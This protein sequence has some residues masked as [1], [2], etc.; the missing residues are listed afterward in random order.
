MGYKLYREVLDHASADLTATERLVLAVIADDANDTTRESW[1]PSP[2]WLAH[3]A[4]ST[5]TAIH[6]AIQRL[7]RRGYELRVPVKVGVDGRPVYAHK[8]R[9]TTYRIP[10]FPARDVPPRSLKARTDC[11]PSTAPAPVDNQKSPDNLSTQTPVDNPAKGGQVVPKGWTDSPPATQEGGQRVDDPSSPS[12]QQISSGSTQQQQRASQIVMQ[13]TDAT[14]KQAK[15]VLA[16]IQAEKNPRRMVGLLNRMAQDGDLP[17]WLDRVRTNGSRADLASWIATL[18][19]LPPC[20]HGQHGG[21]QLRPDNGQPQCPHC[22]A[23]WRPS[24]TDQ[25]VAAALAAGARLQA[26]REHRQRLEKA[27]LDQQPLPEITA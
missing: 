16:L 27:Q 24:T 21:D 25:R 13:H 11:P 5:I 15:A 12:T 1:S 2:E 6:K 22:R 19:D 8:G 3:R 7:G 10:R 18:Q 23:T 17:E 9:A 14:E 20:T 26:Q 4:G